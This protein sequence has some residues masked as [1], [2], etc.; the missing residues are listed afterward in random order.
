MVYC[1]IMWPIAEL[2]ASGRWAPGTENEPLMA[3]PKLQIATATVCLCS[4]PV[5]LGAGCQTYLRKVPWA[6]GRGPWG[7]EQCGWSEN[8]GQ[9]CTTP[10]SPA[11]DGPSLLKKVMQWHAYKCG[12]DDLIEQ[13][14][15]QWAAW[16]RKYLSIVSPAHP[17]WHCG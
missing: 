5:L 1:L 15:G 10:M 11:F 17:W 3:P 6:T 4:T 16:A 13:V 14:F 7:C 9:P 8:R 2:L 12:D